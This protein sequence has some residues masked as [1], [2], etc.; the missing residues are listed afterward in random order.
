MTKGFNRSVIDK[1]IENIK[2]VEDSEEENPILVKE[3][4][5][6]YRKHHRLMG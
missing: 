1:A 6:L 3:I 2:L 5:K 4:K